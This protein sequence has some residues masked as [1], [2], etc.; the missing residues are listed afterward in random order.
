MASI[1]IE[2]LRIRG[3]AKAVRALRRYPPQLALL[4]QI[5]SDQLLPAAVRIVMLVIDRIAV[6][7]EDPVVPIAENQLRGVAFHIAIIQRRFRHAVA[8]IAEARFAP[9]QLIDRV[10]QRQQNPARAVAQVDQPHRAVGKGGQN[11]IAAAGKGR[12]PVLAQ[13][14]GCGTVQRLRVETLA[15]HA[16]AQQRHV[17]SHGSR[18]RRLLGRVR[19]RPAF[20]AAGRKSGRQQQRQQQA[21]QFF[22]KIL[23]SLTAAASGATG[24]ADNASSAPDDRAPLS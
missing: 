21:K 14:P 9:V 18:G 19:R 24:R 5:E 16:Q 2:D 6:A 22:H 20:L 1:G 23:L 3:P 8:G 12:H 17:R 11:L 7:V 13:P 15:L 10:F 4:G